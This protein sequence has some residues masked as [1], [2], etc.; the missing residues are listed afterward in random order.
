MEDDLLKTTWEEGDL[1]CINGVVKVYIA[2]Q[3]R[4]REIPE[5]YIGI[6]WFEYVK[7]N[8]CITAEQAGEQR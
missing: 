8:L 6:L 2:S 4:W 5:D 1:R 3:R 7:R